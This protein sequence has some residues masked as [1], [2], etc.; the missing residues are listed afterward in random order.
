MFL[1]Y[2]NC[3][4]GWIDPQQT[5]QSAK[6]IIVV[7]VLLHSVTGA[8][9]IAVIGM[10]RDKHKG[11]IETQK[12]FSHTCLV[13]AENRCCETRIQENTWLDG[14]RRNGAPQKTAGLRV[15]FGNAKMSIA[16]LASA[17]ETKNRPSAICDLIPVVGFFFDECICSCKPFI[18]FWRYEIYEKISSS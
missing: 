6:G 10:S 11:G 14:R 7:I 17:W 13:S 1:S 18:Q 12:H 16:L 9:G 8:R 15:E 5:E 2:S 4:D 3:A